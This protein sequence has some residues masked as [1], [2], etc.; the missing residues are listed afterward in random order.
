MDKIKALLQKAG[1]SAE[2]AGQICESL[3]SYKKTLRERFEAEYAAKV[4]AAKK[5][6][7]DETE[8]HKRELARR[9]QIFC[10]T[11]GAA[12]EASLAKQSALSESEALNKLRDI[13]SLLQGHAPSNGAQNNGQPT[14]VIAKAK[15]KIQAVAEERN[16]AVDAANRAN[17]LAEKMLKRNRL[18]ETRL[19]RLALEPTGGDS[20]VSEGLGAPRGRRI[21]GGRK[22]PR[23]VDQHQHGQQ[24]LKVRIGDHLSLQATT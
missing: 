1:V 12:V 19:K 23:V 4:D 9:V 22:R 15:Q 16:R 8:N 7:I 21:D 13:A 3:D 10:E 24:W 11:K 6:C 14:A 20:V 17:S 18:L 2:L 5:I